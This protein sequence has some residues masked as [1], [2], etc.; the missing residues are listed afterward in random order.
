MSKR[1]QT[2]VYRDSELAANYGERDAYAAFATNAPINRGY[3]FNVRA[4]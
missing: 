4:P 3:N 2:A 1:P